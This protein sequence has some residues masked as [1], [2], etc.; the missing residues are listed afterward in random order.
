MDVRDRPAIRLART[1]EPSSGNA[2]L[3]PKTRSLSVTEE[4]A[5]SGAFANLLC[6]SNS[7]NSH[8]AVQLPGL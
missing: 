7:P 5:D 6:H 2:C 1:Y 8:K 3:T 4:K